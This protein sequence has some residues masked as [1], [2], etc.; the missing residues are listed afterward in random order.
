MPAPACDA[1]A[2]V[3]S[4]IRKKEQRFKDYLSMENLAHND[5]HHKS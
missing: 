3:R 4:N 1:A 2:A 5:G